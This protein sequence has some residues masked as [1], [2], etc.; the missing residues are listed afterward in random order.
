MPSPQ[1]GRSVLYSS[2]QAAIRNARFE[3]AVELFAVQELVAHR[4][5]EA[6][7]E[8]VL[9]RCALLDEELLDAAL[10]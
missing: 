2:I 1:C 3:Q 8:G 7:D 6:L 4:A 5:V 10:A 9:L